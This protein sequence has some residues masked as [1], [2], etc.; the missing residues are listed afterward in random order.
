MKLA[1]KQSIEQLKRELKKAATKN[2]VDRLRAAARSINK[3]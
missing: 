2:A 3:T 1:I